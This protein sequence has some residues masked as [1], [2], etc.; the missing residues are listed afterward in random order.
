M[1]NGIMTNWHDLDT[2]RRQLRKQLAEVL[3]CE[4]VVL[5]GHNTTADLVADLDES[6]K[7]KLREEGYPVIDP[8]D[9]RLLVRLGVDYVSGNY[10]DLGVR[11]TKFFADE[12]AKNWVELEGARTDQQQIDLDTMV[13]QALTMMV[14]GLRVVVVGHSQGNFF[15]NEVY[16]AIVR[17]GPG[18][19]AKMEVVGLATPSSR[20]AGRS[21]NPVEYTTLNADPIHHV[22]FNALDPTTSA[23][24]CEATTLPGSIHCHFLETYLA[25]DEPW[26]RLLFHLL[27]GTRRA[28]V[29]DTYSVGADQTFVAPTGTLLLNDRVPL[30]ASSVSF[31][32]APSFIQNTG[33]G[34]FRVHASS[35]NI[36]RT[37]FE[38]IY[39]TIAGQSNQATVT[40][41]VVGTP[42]PEPVENL[43]PIAHF[44]A[45]HETAT[46]A[47]GQTL[48]VI[49]DRTTGEARVTFTDQSS[50]PDGDSIASRTWTADT[51]CTP[52]GTPPCLL[53]SGAATFTWGFRAGTYDITLRVTDGH[54]GEDTATARI[55]VT[56]A[57]P[58]ARVWPMNGHD[59][60]RTSRS[61]SA[62]P[63]TRPT[64][65]HWVFPTAEPV[66]GGLSVSAEGRLYF[67]S[68]KFYALGSDGQV[69]AQAPVAAVSGKAQPV[70]T[71]AAID[72]VNGFVY[73]GTY[74]PGGG[75]DL[76]RFNKDL[77]AP[78]VL[79]HGDQQDGQPSDVIVDDQGGVFFF[80]NHR[81]G[82]VA[83]A[84]GSHSWTS[85]VCTTRWA[86]AP[87]IGA[88]GHVYG[89]CPGV[90]N[91]K[92]DRTTG[93][94][95][96]RGTASGTELM[97][98]DTAHL[99]GG[100]QQFT[101]V[102]FIGGF[103]SWN[104]DL[105]LA[106]DSCCGE[107]TTGRASLFPDGTST[108]RTGYAFQDDRILAARGTDVW[109]MQVAR[110]G[111]FTTDP[112]VDAS[113]RVFV[114]ANAGLY[115]LRQVDGTVD[116]TFAT[117]F[118]VTGQPVIADGAVYFATTNGSVYKLRQQAGPQPTGPTITAVEPLTVYAGLTDQL[119]R[120]SGTGFS[121]PEPSVATAC[122][123]VEVYLDGSLLAT[124]QAP[125][126][127][128]SVA[129]A[130]MKLAVTFGTPGVYSLVAVNP[131]GSRSVPFDISVQ[132]FQPAVASKPSIV[133][134]DGNLVPQV[135]GRGL[136]GLVSD[137]HGNLLTLKIASPCG[138]SACRL[139]TLL[140]LSPYGSVNWEATE[141]ETEGAS[142]FGGDFQAPLIITPGADDDVFLQTSRIHVGGY[143]SGAMFGNWPQAAVGDRFT[144]RLLVDETTGNVFVTTAPAFPGAEFGA[145]VFDRNGSP[146][147]LL[148]GTVGTWYRGAGG[149]PYLVNGLSLTRYDRETLAPACSSSLPDFVRFSST[150]GIFTT[151]G[152]TIYRTDANC[153]TTALATVAGVSFS[154]YTVHGDRLIGLS[155]PDLFGTPGTLTGVNLVN[156]TVWTQGSLQFNGDSIGSQGDTIYMLVLDRADGL[157][158]KVAILDAR[159]GS[160]LAKLNT[161]G[162]CENNCHLEVAADGR[163]YL[164]ESGSSKVFRVPRVIHAGGHTKLEF[165]NVDEMQ[166]LRVNGQLLAEETG[167]R[168]FEL[169]TLLQPGL[170]LV[171]VE[172]VNGAGSWSFGYNLRVDGQT[173]VSVSCG[174]SGGAGCDGDSQK[175]GTVLRESFLILK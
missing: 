135:A 40:V 53:A 61:G 83:Y 111:I 48:N 37:Q 2:N 69:F 163:V 17:T 132:T 19:A 130:S 8:A 11:A 175:L 51:P 71:S 128:Q 131:D 121:C 58:G 60:R 122:S 162:F 145:T 154:I 70:V 166:T 151:D 137:R 64:S 110:P 174:Q 32:N 155:R 153:Q 82:A 10:V 49:T 159:S 100:F 102:I 147:L 150:E 126:Q 38:Y 148:P 1:I 170:N 27:A 86:G 172:V 57:D 141:G 39:T 14:A 103:S 99:W 108:V 115:V 173:A 72:D 96:A 67:A 28:A 56:A 16:D 21:G 149:H 81:S 62:G 114:G 20:V 118:P 109:S 129:T 157:K 65:P 134:F 95:L 9:F 22:V 59:A 25:K 6:V 169:A 143:R 124:L 105:T 42:P 85:T 84:L 43:A 63:A 5:P 88:D 104:P 116:W 107:Y 4:V 97:I 13:Q 46:V 34:G 15:A 93:V 68:D 47:N 80:V 12:L 144:G 161:S 106:S 31:L 112:S 98:D 156:G 120:L 171:E 168:S 138:D 136:V 3:G 29:D 41:D 76:L 160:I 55:E 139:F 146:S 94:E 92:L 125:G 18:L 113:G 52:G 158:Q 152:T 26:R 90:G 33:D 117:P 91:L 165:F 35:Q 167:S 77:S 7:Q 140:S 79:E 89:A 101:G 30:P 73:F 133:A 24:T 45:S 23:P 66:V 127:V 54:G 123:S 164:Q 78:I 50:D 36:G 75:W 74:S 119:I 44:V 87:A 142:G